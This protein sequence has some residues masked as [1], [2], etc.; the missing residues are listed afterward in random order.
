[1]YNIEGLR[2]DVWHDLYTSGYSSITGYMIGIT[3]G[4][5]FYKHRNKVLTIN[6]VRLKGLLIF[7][8]IPCVKPLMRPNCLCPYFKKLLKKNAGILQLLN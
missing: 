3:F 1:M 4:Y 6:R 8:I 2:L 5:L 7:V